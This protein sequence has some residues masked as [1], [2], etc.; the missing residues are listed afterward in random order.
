[1]S[2][3]PSKAQENHP[4]LTTKIY[5]PQLRPALVPR[6]RLIKRLSE[7]M[8][9]KFV[10]VS[11]PAGFGKTTLLSDWAR[12]D[13]FPVAWFSI[14]SSD[15]NPV[16]FYSYVIAALQTVDKNIGKAALGMLQSP[17]PPPLESA[18]ITALNSI[19]PCLH[20]FALVLDDYH[21]VDNVKIHN[22]LAFLI[23]H[24]PTQ[25]HLILATRAD[26]PFHLARL[27]ARNQL[28]EIRAIDLCF[29]A[30]EI[31]DL[32][33][34]RL[35]LE[36]SKNDIEML[37]SRT[38][39]WISGLQLAAHS[40]RER[41]DKSAF[42]KEFKGDNRHIVD[43]LGEEVL[44][45]QPEAIQ[46]FLM[47]TS[48]LNRM[49]APL[50]EAITKQ[51]DCQ[52]MLDEL[53]KADL[54]IF[55]L[56]SERHWFRYHHLFADLLQQ[57]LG[58]FQGD[59]VRE[60]HRRACEWYLRNEYREEAMEHAL[61]A[62]NFEQ[63]SDLL[64]GLA[65]SVWD[66]DQQVSM[67]R[68]FAAIPDEMLSSRLNL[69]IYYA[70]SLNMAGREE[71][72]E[73][74]LQA[75]EHI[76]ESM[77][78]ESTKVL[79]LNSNHPGRLNKSE[80][81]GRIATIRA[82][83]SAYKGDLEGIKQHARTAIISLNERDVLWRS[84]AATT[85]GFAHGW[86][87]DGDMMSAR[88]AFS[89]AIAVSELGGNTFFY[90]FSRSCLAHIDAHQ[91]RL[92]Q[93]EESYRQLLEYADDNDLCLTSLT[94]SII[95]SLG[96]ILCEKNEVEEG[97]QLVQEG[98]KQILQGHDYVTLVACKLNMARILFNKSELDQALVQIEDIEKTVSESEVPPWIMH[99][100][101][102]LKAWLWLRRGQRDD[103][104]RWVAER[105]LEYDT[106]LTYR[107][108]AEHVVLV[109]FLLTQGKY[110]EAGQWLDRLLTDAE[111]GMRVWSVIQMRLLKAQI[112]YA[113]NMLPAALDELGMALY[114]G[115]PGKF[116]R[117][118]VIESD[119]V[120]EML[121]RFLEKE[122][123]AIDEKHCGYSRS[124]VKKL[125][126]AFKAEAVPKRTT[127]LD[128]PLS[129]R[130]LDVLRL[131]AAGLSNKEIAQKLFVS[132]NTIRTHTKNINAKLDVH[133]RT[134]A[135]ARAK[136]L[137]LL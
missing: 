84:V 109:R 38:E 23:D 81:L 120:Q 125:L 119:P 79:T 61:A 76:L 39:G 59:M 21:L 114:L 99:E 17:H 47:Q 44:N 133:S 86:S 12:Q 29:T 30:E 49:S 71:E 66:R 107:R 4:F 37:V 131:I 83:I 10:L 60:L 64:E 93:A 80:L 129:E 65:E 19:P 1:M 111:A 96:L 42:I 89:E 16:L 70:R 54:F 45:H 98:L 103:V 25:M 82:F 121:E 73:A 104:S 137:G 67:L 74:K 51:S 87:G 62:E 57:R 36:L 13:K 48:I 91:G 50:C 33:S 115:E 56:D 116:V 101:S 85:L 122:K 52:N 108:E 123:S 40:L 11:A 35:G 55:P 100:T 95:S 117:A 53:D 94:A 90:L 130:E 22:A 41:S 58:Q 34:V 112:L 88:F 63:V 124:Y 106:V 3:I 136:E 32:F 105:D 9:H 46:N 14:D 128:E 7:G 77:K 28:S 27:R 132:L 20:H 113:Q 110:N 127:G 8:E 26:P 92:K 126:S 43:Y 6:P 135:V 72:A 118:F 78:E 68:W 31:E 18:L 5:V 134:Q 24:L 69:L 102:A 15:N 2:K 75:A 97:T